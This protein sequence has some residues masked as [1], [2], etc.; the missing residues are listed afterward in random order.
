MDMA[1]ALPQSMFRTYIAMDTLDFGNDYYVEAP[2]S[3][4]SP[5][6][7]WDLSQGIF[8]GMISLIHLDST[9][10]RSLPVHGVML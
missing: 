3:T 6:E 8:R 1:L 9:T 2:L 5:P 10:Q 7:E 4:F